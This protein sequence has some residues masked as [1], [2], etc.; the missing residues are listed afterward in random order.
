MRAGG[1]NWW[2]SQWSLGSGHVALLGWG[3]RCRP[4]QQQSSPGQKPPQTQVG[5]PTA[6]L[7]H[8][9]GETA[10]ALSALLP[11]SFQWFHTGGGLFSGRV[12][13]RM[14]W[15]SKEKVLYRHRVSTS[16]MRSIPPAETLLPAWSQSFLAVKTAIFQFFRG[17]PF[18]AQEKSFGDIPCMK[19][20]RTGCCSD[21]RCTE[22]AR[23]GQ[24]CWGFVPFSR[25][26]LWAVAPIWRQATP[27]SLRLHPTSFPCSFVLLTFFHPCLNL[28]HLT[29][30]P[31]CLVWIL[32]FFE[33]FIISDVCSF[34]LVSVDEVGSVRVYPLPHTSSLVPCLSLPSPYISV[35]MYSI[36]RIHHLLE[37]GRK[38]LL[39]ELSLSHGCRGDQKTLHMKQWHPVPAWMK[40]SIKVCR[41][42]CF[43]SSPTKAGLRSALVEALGWS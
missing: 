29:F 8:N 35:S 15:D 6:S 7:P 27:P 39:R 13:S 16:C 24:P 30:L 3:G 23:E 17:R 25:L 21:P 37:S 38:E 10:S 34:I 5:H 36:F 9:L 40:H 12:A 26:G 14:E 18:L 28:A 1:G 11:Q 2:A 19:H 22:A 33:R 20:V 41:C 4:G 43:Y 42:Y 32:F 31:W